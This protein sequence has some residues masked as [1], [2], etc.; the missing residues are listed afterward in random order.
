LANRDEQ[1]RQQGVTPI[2]SSKGKVA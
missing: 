2:R 1:Q